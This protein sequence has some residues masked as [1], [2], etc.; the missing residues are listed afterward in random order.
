MKQI[1]YKI[2]FFLI[3]FFSFFAFAKNSFASGNTYYVCDTVSSCNANGGSGWSGTPSDSNSGATKA[4]P[5]KTISGGIGKM[6]GGDTLVI[7]NGTYAGI[8][9]MFTTGNGN[10]LDLTSK[11]GSSGAYTVIKA[12]ND[13]GVT[14]DGQSSNWT[15]YVKNFNYGIIRGI[16]FANSAYIAL[17]LGLCDHIKVIR[18]TFQEMNDFGISLT[19]VSDSS[20]VGTTNSLVEQC[21]AWGSG[22]YFFNDSN[23]WGKN[24]HNIWRSNI[25]RRDFYHSGGD[26][27]HYGSFTTYFAATNDVF[28]QNSI[29]VDS[30]TAGNIGVDENWYSNA[31]LYTANGGKGV[32]VNGFV[33]INDEGIA[34]IL[35][36]ATTASIT[37]GAWYMNEVD[38]QSDGIYSYAANPYSH[39]IVHGAVNDP[40]NDGAKGF[41]QVSGTVSGLTNSIFYGNQV[42]LQSVSNADYN[43]VNGNSTAYA[44]MS[45]G[46]NDKSYAPTSN[47]L[48]YPVRIESGSNL[49]TAGSGGGQIGPTILYYIGRAGSTASCGGTVD[50][51]LSCQTYTDTGWNEI[52]DGQSGRELVKLWPFPNEDK[53]KTMMAAYDL[54]GVSGARGFA[55][56]GNDTWG[57]PITLTRYIWEYLGNQIPDDIYETSSDT[58]PPAAPSGLA[59]N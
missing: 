59:V 8:S 32:T 17:R 5:T 10:W 12:E 18:C 15:G 57:Q 40:G 16:N 58:T 52:Q 28:F 27:N 49:A 50:N 51:D 44:G 24:D 19:G 41:W 3:I 35:E 56:S 7:G 37:N 6:S 43:D 9:N 2:I 11:S 53:I 20:G 38:G 55:A 14:I 22:S 42:G 48:L 25:A 34:A 4:L 33:S 26:S 39:I 31:S 1:N 54:H 45:A 13:W 36:S 23:Y 29:S 21:A 46:A 47:G 30:T